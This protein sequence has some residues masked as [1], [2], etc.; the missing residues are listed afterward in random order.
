ML[1]L[2][3]TAV[4]D[5][6][7]Q[8][9]SGRSIEGTL[10]SIDNQS[11]VI[12]TLQGR[13]TIDL[14]D[15]RSITTGL[16]TSPDVES[17]MVLTLRNGTR[18]PVRHYVQQDG[19]ATVVH[20]ILGKWKIPGRCISHVLLQHQP[21]GS[22]FAKQ[23]QALI[24]N[25]PKRDLVV[26]R[27]EEALD[28]LEGVIHTV[29]EEKLDFAFEGD[30]ISPRRARLEGISFFHSPIGEPPATRFQITDRHGGL[31]QVSTA[32]LD[33]N[34]LIFTT[35][36]GASARLPLTAIA[37]FDFVASNISYLSDMKMERSTWRPYLQF[38]PVSSLQQD[39][40]G[41]KRDRTLNGRPLKLN[42][43]VYSKG[44]A[45][46]SRTEISY[47]LQEE[48]KTFRAIVGLDRANIGK[49]GGRAELIVRADGDREL[50]RCDLSV[51]A[52]PVPIEVKLESVRR[53]TIIV[54]FGDE[55]D[56]G[57]H[58]LLCEARLT[59]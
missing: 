2:A 30:R 3:L 1:L 8:T 58:V 40:F 44:L 37:K 34:D 48:Y 14:L 47:R 55:N 32:R 35:P 15:L 4:V 51:D 43:R 24:A 33:G 59:K 7:A 20:A 18:I 25:S 21:E 16:D 26:F 49:I 13:E 17:R 5:V 50:F 31:W 12:Q 54:D 45:L 41:P 19:E 39:H 22:E 28:H 53:L 38:G 11:V 42:G 6:N 27:R 56:I 46:H 36:S 9:L 23:W 29:G 52:L 57:D 10:T